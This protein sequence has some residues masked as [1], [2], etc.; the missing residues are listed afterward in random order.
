[1]DTLIKRFIAQLEE[2]L[3]IGLQLKLAPMQHSTEK[4]VICGMGGSGIG[5]D[6]VAK[7]VWEEAAVPVIVHKDYGLPGFVDPHTL[8]IISSYS[9]NTEESLSA[10]EEAIPTGARIVCV[11]SGGRVGD[12][13][14]SKGLDLVEIPAGWPS[15]RACLGYSMLTQLFILQRLGLTDIPLESQ[16]RAAIGLLK[17]EQEAIR[18]EASDIAVRLQGKLPVLYGP[19]LYEPVLLRFRQQFNEN[20]KMLAWHN[21]IPEM[22]HNELVGWTQK[23]DRLAVVFFSSDDDHPKVTQRINIIKGILIEYVDTMISIRPKGNSYLER[24]LYLV[25]LVDWISWYLAALDGT[26]ANEI[27]VIDFLKERLAVK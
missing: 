18:K 9:G 6:F 3:E 5:G 13:A 15:P 16:L 11:S 7:V 10:L 27:R 19:A 26:D 1:M 12:L 20:A 2:G 25:H 23:E 14:R 24:T 17:A 22:N 21:V 4:V 8:V